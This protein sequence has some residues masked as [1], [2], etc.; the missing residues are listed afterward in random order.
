MTRAT[1]RVPRWAWITSR[2]GREPPARPPVRGRA[3]RGASAGSGR[4]ALAAQRRLELLLGLVVERGLDHF[5]A[6]VRDPR[7]DLVWRRLA[8]EH[9]DRR[10]VV[11]EVRA[12][13]L[14]ELVV[15]ADVGERPGRTARG[16]AD[17]HAEERG[18]KD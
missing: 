9:D 10:A 8:H 2:I 14:E 17:R 16:R 18:E 5:A 11:A 13:L 1:W 3:G 4:G 15:H 12:E 6:V 7:Q